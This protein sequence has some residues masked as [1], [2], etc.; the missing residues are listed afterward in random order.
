GHYIPAS[1]FDYYRGLL[2]NPE[3]LAERN[4]A[5]FQALNDAAGR[6]FV[7]TVAALAQKV[8]TPEAFLRG[9]RVL[10]TKEMIDRDDLVQALLEAG[11]QRQPSVYDPGIFAVRGGVIDVFCPL[12]LQPVRIEFFGDEIESIRFFEAQSQRS[13]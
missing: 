4:A 1:E 13:L 10:G 12:Y 2:P 6:V 8:L 5:L 11:Y 7:T 3:L 9:T